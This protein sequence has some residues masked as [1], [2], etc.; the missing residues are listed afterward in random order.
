MK[1]NN[2]TVIEEIKQT[3]F[4]VNSFNSNKSV[5]EWS[6]NWFD[7]KNAELV[8]FLLCLANLILVFHCAK[9]FKPIKLRLNQQIEKTE[10]QTCTVW[11][12]VWL[13]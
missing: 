11:F 1:L 4:G 13:L 10:T 2:A 8:W 9:P 5:A 12:Q 7:W 6:G 3:K